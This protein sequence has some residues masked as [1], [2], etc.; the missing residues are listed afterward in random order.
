VENQHVTCAWC[1]ERIGVYEPVVVVTRVGARTTSFARKRDLDR[2][3]S[4]LLHATC[5]AVVVPAA[6]W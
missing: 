3:D 1:G 5:A 6:T 4:L 2:T